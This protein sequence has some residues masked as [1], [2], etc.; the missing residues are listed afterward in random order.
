MFVSNSTGLRIPIFIWFPVKRT[1]SLPLTSTQTL[2]KGEE[3]SWLKKI[4]MKQ[5][6]AVIRHW[7]GCKKKNICFA[8]GW[9]GGV[10]AKLNLCCHVIDPL[11]RYRTGPSFKLNQ[12]FLHL[13][14]QPCIFFDS[15]GL[16]NDFLIGGI[17]LAL[18]QPAGKKKGF[19]M[20]M[21]LQLIRKVSSTFWSRGLTLLHVVPSPF[22]LQIYC[23]LGYLQRYS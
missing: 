7:N 10:P 23:Q 21:V 2:Q 1:G 17:V 20:K 22:P 5:H 3:H 16:D 8:W 9:D 15:L 13:R 19:L 4:Q 11:L 6:D 18:G 12:W 14:F